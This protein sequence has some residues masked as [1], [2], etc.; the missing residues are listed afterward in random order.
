[1]TLPKF[2]YSQDEDITVAEVIKVQ[3]GRSPEQ[4]NH[5][6]V[7]SRIANKEKLDELYSE[8]FTEV[9]E[10][11]GDNGFST[12]ITDFIDFVNEKYQDVEDFTFMEIQSKPELTWSMPF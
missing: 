7:D 5:V 12:S 6:F 2:R 10:A 8:Y 1:M 3:W 11:G 4:F 9:K